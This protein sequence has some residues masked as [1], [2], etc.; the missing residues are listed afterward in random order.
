MLS[1]KL[2]AL[3]EHLAA[4]S[5]EPASPIVITLL[6]DHLRDLADL[7]RG[8]EHEPVPPHMRGALPPGVLRFPGRAA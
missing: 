4:H 3:A 6:A 5:G 2:S 8:L 7:A 1:T